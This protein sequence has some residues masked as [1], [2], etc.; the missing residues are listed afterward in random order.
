MPHP[1]LLINP[2]KIQNTDTKQREAKDGD[3]FRNIN[4]NVEACMA[5]EGCDMVSSA[6]MKQS[7]NAHDYL[8]HPSLILSNLP[9]DEEG[10]FVIEKDQFEAFSDTGYELNVFAYNN[11]TSFYMEKTY[12]RD[13]KKKEE[14]S[15]VLLRKLKFDSAFDP[16]LHFNNKDIITC[17]YPEEQTELTD[18][19]NI[20][21]YVL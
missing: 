17:C 14:K 21:L 20:A 18:I 3:R 1:G 11:A 15:P 4:D 13:T 12:C 8:K 19:K 9:I 5:K 16:Q 6:G 2:R 10:R 7:F